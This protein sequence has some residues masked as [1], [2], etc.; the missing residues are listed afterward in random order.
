M[1]R[2]YFHR[3]LYRNNSILK[4]REKNIR[5]NQKEKIGDQ[6]NARDNL[7]PV[8]H[9]FFSLKKKNIYIYIS[10]FIVQVRRTKKIVTELVRMLYLNRRNTANIFNILFVVTKTHAA[11]RGSEPLNENFNMAVSTV[12]LDP[13]H[14]LYR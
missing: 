10:V 13:K 1:F 4:T 8:F 11:Q 14:K 9:F 5:C 7:N 3:R 12:V 2:K 6:T